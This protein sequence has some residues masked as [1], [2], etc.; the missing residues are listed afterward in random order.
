MKKIL[1]LCM[2]LLFTGMSNAQTKFQ[3]A[4]RFHKG[5]SVG[6]GYQN[7]QLLNTIFDQSLDDNL[8]KGGGGL[9]LQARYNIHPLTLKFAYGKSTFE[10][11][12][13][14]VKKEGED[15]QRPIGLTSLNFGGQLA[16]LPGRRIFTPF[17]GGGYSNGELSLKAEESINGVASR[18]LL[19]NPYFDTGFILSAGM[20]FLEVFYQRTIPLNDTDH[21][22]YYQLGI[23]LAMNITFIRKY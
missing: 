11:P 22:V 18:I 14:A 8:I 3:E 10:A 15:E 19:Q 2:G 6:I 20:V 9:N 1:L 5:F 16:L 23:N 17:V 13:I 4:Y 7:S 21:K 12:G